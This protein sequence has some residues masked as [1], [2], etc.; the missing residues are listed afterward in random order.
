[1]KYLLILNILI[2]ISIL[3]ELNKLHINFDTCFIDIL[4]MTYITVLIVKWNNL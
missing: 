1:M 4:L 2:I 3:M